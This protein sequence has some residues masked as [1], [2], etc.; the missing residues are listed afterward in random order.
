MY[1]FM[2]ISVMTHAREKSMMPTDAKY[3]IYGGS[4]SGQ[5]SLTLTVKELYAHNY[6]NM[7]I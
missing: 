4:Y 1:K 7:H 6:D 3:S 5:F 2:N